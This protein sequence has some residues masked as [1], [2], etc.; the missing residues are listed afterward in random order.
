[1]PVTKDKF[2]SQGRPHDV[3]KLE[4]VME[5]D[6]AYTTKEIVGMVGKTPMRVGCKLRE[7]EEQKK[8]ERR[9]IDGKVYWILLPK[10]YIEGTVKNKKIV[11]PRGRPRME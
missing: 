4:E 7:L 5:P 3:M 8:A 9:W 10:C 1:M 6:T 2:M 11:K